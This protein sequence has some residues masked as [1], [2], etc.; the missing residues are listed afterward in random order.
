MQRNRKHRPIH[1]RVVAER[2]PAGAWHTMSWREGTNAPLS[3]RFAATRVRPARLDYR[4]KSARPQEWLLI[5][6]PEGMSEPER[7]WMS[8]LP[9]GTTLEDL[10]QT[11]KIRWRI[12][13]DYQELKQEF[14]LGHYEGRGWRGFHHHATLCIAVFG[15][16]MAHRIKQSRVKKNSAQSKT[17]T[18]PRGYTARGSRQDATSRTGLDRDAAIP[19]RSAN[20]SPT[21]TMS[22]RMSDRPKAPYM[23]Q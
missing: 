9:A 22:M 20:R 15:F 10:V 18:L 19:R 23:T 12:E 1:V 14:G 13:R 8:T 5:E 17:P 21:R 6:W 7:Y 4:R 2:L 11:A 16:L 3:S